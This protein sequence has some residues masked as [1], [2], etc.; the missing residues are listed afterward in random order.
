MSD[1]LENQ[2]KTRS[3][4][5]ATDAYAMSIGEVISLYQNKELDI[6]PEFQRFFRW[7]IGQKSNFIESLLLGIPIPSLF[8][9]QRDNGVWELVDGLQRIS[10]I[11]QL[12][13]ELKDKDGKKVE[14]LTLSKTDYLPALEGLSWNS[15]DT[16]KAIPQ[17]AKLK[18]RRSRLDLKIVLNTSDKKAKFELFRRLNTGGSLATD[19][20]VRNCLMLMVNNKFFEWF[21]ELGNSDQFR[22]CL[23]L[24]ERAVEEAYNHEL[25]TRF[26]VLRQSDP[27]NI[28]S[29]PDLGQYLTDKILEICDND[30]FDYEQETSAFI[31][32]FGFL[33]RTLGEDSFKKF[34]TSKQRASGA[35][36]VSIFEVI[37]IGI[38]FYANQIDFSSPNF[39]IQKIHENLWTDNNMQSTTGSGVSAS[40]RIPKTLSLG[41]SLFTP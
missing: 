33:S 31:S 24:T 6:H 37:A 21:M 1:A 32:T 27:D 38:G 26:I 8:M 28:K 18:I 15:E 40:L 41:R 23:P 13:G 14:G 29:I 5:I 39:D 11:L 9:A 3:Q 25:L 4:E 2:I 36:L 16:A 10:T 12:V 7:T 35:V 22:S 34:D 17:S 30:E 20:E 19:Q